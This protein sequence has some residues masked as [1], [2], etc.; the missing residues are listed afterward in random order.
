MRKYPVEDQRRSSSDRRSGR[1]RRRILVDPTYCGIERRSY[2]ER[3]SGEERRKWFRLFLKL[4]CRPLYPV[5]AHERL[6]GKQ[7]VLH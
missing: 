7:I 2:T 3:R 6:P 4:G 5:S 1:D